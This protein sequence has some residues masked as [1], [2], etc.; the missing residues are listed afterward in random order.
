MVLL[1]LGGIVAAEEGTTAPGKRRK[2][3]TIDRFF[4]GTVKKL[5]KKK[6]RIVLFYDFE[7]PKQLL[8]F[9]EVRPPRLLNVVSNDV[10]IRKGRL[11][12]RG[13]SGIRHKIEG[14]ARYRAHFWVKIGRRRNIGTH[15]TEPLL[16]ENYI[17]FNLFDYR[18]YKGGLLH[19][20]A[21][22]LHEDGGAD[23][24]RSLVNHRDLF[25]SPRL[26]KVRVGDE[27]EV[28]VTKDGRHEF[29]RVNE[30]KGRSSSKGKMRSLKAY[31]FGFF[32]HESEASFDNLTLDLEVTDTFLRMNDVLLELAGDVDVQAAPATGVLAGIGGIPDAV[33]EAIEAFAAGR[34]DASPVIEALAN[35]E[36][37]ARAREIAA[38]LVMQRKDPRTVPSL[39]TKLYSDDLET[40]ELATRA[41]KAIVG[42]DF[43]Y[44]PAAREESRSKA[45]AAFLKHLAENRERYY[46]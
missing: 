41:I 45:L 16:S 36:L 46:G 29:V 23:V 43:G 2:R 32:V 10:G 8:D 20:C 30:V 27:L 22:G 26:K 42:Q 33:R 17:L 3:I 35:K 5:D 19:L 28:E 13:S 4:N 15:F 18:I 11:V 14:T 1:L 37:P 39:V 9:E 40:R 12:L 24:D 21:I 6:K 7:D 34:G 25:I 31:Q 38:D 44:D